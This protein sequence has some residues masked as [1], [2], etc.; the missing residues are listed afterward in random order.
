[1]ENSAL[2]QGAGDVLDQFAAGEA[3]GHEMG[4]KRFQANESWLEIACRTR[5]LLSGQ[6]GQAAWI[7]A[8][9]FS[10]QWANPLW[11][12]FFD[13]TAQEDELLERLFATM[14]RVVGSPWV[15]EPL[16]KELLAGSALALGTVA[17][18]WNALA[19]TLRRLRRALMR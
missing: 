3:S 19:K 1:M 18:S 9:T 15:W 6:I 11:E 13:V 5:E 14:R 8:A 10:L 12:A 16:Q 17:D 4:I 2:P 7:Q